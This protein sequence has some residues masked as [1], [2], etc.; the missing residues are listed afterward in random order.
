SA[1]KAQVTAS[2]EG[3]KPGSSS[4]SPSPVQP[5]PLLGVL[6]DPTLDDRHDLLRGRGNVDLAG[7]IAFGRDLVGQF[8]AEAAARQAHD[9]HA[10]DRAIDIAA[11]AGEQLVGACL[12]A[13][14]SDL[15]AAV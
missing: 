6:A 3:G 8:G 13:E 5:E 7:C 14:E 10:V 4:L 2:R 1:C 11:D 12:A 15:D 9:T